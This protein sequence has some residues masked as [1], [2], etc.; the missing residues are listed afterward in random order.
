MARAYENL[1]T[2]PISRSSISE[3]FRDEGYRF[4]KA[5]KVL[6]SADPHYREKLDK[7]KTILSHLGSDEKFFSIDE[8]GPI[9]VKIRGGTALVSSNEVRTIPQKQKSKGSL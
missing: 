3:Y 4:K 5:R 1:Y 6:T 9:S 2:T 7:I 8:F